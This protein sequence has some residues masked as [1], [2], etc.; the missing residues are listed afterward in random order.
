MSAQVIV[1]QRKGEGR[2]EQ[3]TGRVS[4]ALEIAKGDNK[5]SSKRKKKNLWGMW[6]AESSSP[7]RCPHSNPQN[8]GIYGL[9]RQEGLSRY[10]KVKNLK[11]GSLSWIF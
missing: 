6:W 4:L 1:Q 5:P 3:L 11:V 8:L 7:Q 9:I 2:P 10:E